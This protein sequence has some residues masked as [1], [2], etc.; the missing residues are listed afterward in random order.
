[1]GVG[2]LK[3]IGKLLLISLL[4]ILIAGVAVAE[5]S[6][7]GVDTI[8]SESFILLE[9][10]SGRVLYEKNSREQSL[11]A[12]T[13]KLMTAI[14]ALELSE[15]DEI[16]TI[17]PESTGIEGCSIYLEPGEQLTM[18]DLLYG[19]ILRSGNDA[20]MAIARHVGGDERQFAALMNRKAW[21]LGMKDTSFANPHGLD[22]EEHYS[23]AHDL[24]ILARE[25]LR[26]PVL[27]EICATETYVSRELTTGRPRVMY[28]SNKLL[29]RDPRALGLKTGWTEAAG[30]CLVA[31]AAEDGMELIAVVMD[32]QALYSDVMKLFNYGFDKVDMKTVIDAGKT[33]TVLPVRGGVERRVPVQ[34]ARQVSFPVYANEMINYEVIPDLPAR[35]EAPLTVGEVVGTAHILIDNQWELSADLQVAADVDAR[36]GL[37]AR[38]A[39]WLRGWWQND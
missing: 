3:T 18:Q 6:D 27:R 9:A 8:V 13:T 25:V 24:A 7:D 26:H 12:S 34:L 11:I 17:E 23:C 1:M 15:L 35:L 37:F 10:S 16:V 31:A 32:T 36:S 30:A 5:Q 29:E 19:L 20:A 21:E 33:V 39:N 4:L 14:V 28:N 22:A 38:I 2:R